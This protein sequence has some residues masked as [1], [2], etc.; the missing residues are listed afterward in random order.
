[1]CNIFVVVFISPSPIRRT[2]FILSLPLSPSSSWK[3]HSLV[4]SLLSFYI[5]L[6]RTTP[7][8]PLLKS[9][10]LSLSLS[11]SS[12]FSQHRRLFV[13]IF[14]SHQYHCFLGL[15]SLPLPLSLYLSSNHYLSLFLNS[16]PS[17]PSLAA[18]QQKKHN[19]SFSTLEQ[20]KILRLSIER[21]Y[22]VALRFFQCFSPR[23][24]P[25]ISK[26]SSHQNICS[27]KSPIDA[28]FK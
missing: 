2:S 16:Y 23:S 5:F 6:L 18:R 24:I 9:L 8:N 4:P 26:T 21:E 27:T 12:S 11:L 14:L 28:E 22:L 25:R 1:M 17:R 3:P 19:D 15:L 20:A 13:P 7:L 10:S